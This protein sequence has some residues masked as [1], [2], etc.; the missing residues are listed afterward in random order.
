[1]NAQRVGGVVFLVGGMVIIAMRVRRV[2]AVLHGVQLPDG[3]KHRLHQHGE[4][5]QQQCCFD[6]EWAA[7][8]PETHFVRIRWMDAV[9]QMEARPAFCWSNSRKAERVIL[10]M[11]HGDFARQRG[12]D[13][14]IESTLPDPFNARPHPKLQ[15]APQ[16]S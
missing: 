7:A 12:A 14:A 16:R 1:M 8:E 11:G 2:R 13:A 5:K 10:R 6:Q 3:S 4:R 15:E 9:F